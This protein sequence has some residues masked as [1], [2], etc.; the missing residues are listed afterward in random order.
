MYRSLETETVVMK[1]LPADAGVKYKLHSFFIE[2]LV[3]KCIVV[4]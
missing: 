3:S 4:G 1:L 2:M